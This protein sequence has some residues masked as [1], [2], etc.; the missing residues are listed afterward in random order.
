MKNGRIPGMLRWLMLLPLAAVL[1]S[2]SRVEAPIPEE[3]EQAEEK[4]EVQP[5]EEESEPTETEDATVKTIIS[6][7]CDLAGKLGGSEH[8]AARLM[9]CLQGV[10]NSRFE[11]TGLLV[12]QIYDSTDTFWM[13]YMRENAFSD[14][15]ETTLRSAEEY[16]DFFLPYMRECGLVVWDPSVPATANVASTVCGVEHCLPICL[17]GEPDSLYVILT[18]KGVPVRLSLAD[19]F[20]GSGTIPDTE[21]QSSGSAKCDAYLWA[22]EQYGDR[23]S[24][25]LLAYTLDGAGC[26][27]GNPIYD[28]TNE[29]DPFSNQIY[30][31]DYFVMNRA[32]CFDLT[33]NDE[34]PCDD[35]DQPKG[36]DRATLCQ[37][38]QFAY[39][40]NEG[41]ITQIVG[42]PPWWMKYT[43]FHHN[44]HIGEVALEWQ[45]AQLASTYNCAMEADC[46]H[47]CCM[48]NASLYMWYPLE[49]SYEN[50]EPTELPTF[51]GNTRYFT[52]YI[53]DYDSSAWLKSVI[54]GFWKDRTRGTL[55]LG[56]G[57]NPNLSRRIPMV[58]DYLYK[59]KSD[60]DYFLTGDSGAGY[61]NPSALWQTPNVRELPDGAEAWKRWNQPFLD[62]FDMDVCG[63]ILNGALRWTDEVYRMYH[64]L[65]P[66]G[67][68]S[69]SPEQLVVA[70]GTPILSEV[71]YTTPENAYAA[72]RKRISFSVFRTIRQ[73][74]TQIAEEIE[75]IE[76]Y[77]NGQNDGYT[78]RYVGPYELFELIKQSGEGR[79]LE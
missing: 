60:L 67:G 5:H 58:F 22:L 8:D 39:D 13:K 75:A 73:S 53:G 29:H 77:A 6:Y 25:E 14:F 57:L 64:E 59:N 7:S 17:S 28:G 44:S 50:S 11:E 51:D 15:T 10:L 33:S 56:W 63:F 2:C 24:T 32:F 61:V 49:E 74:P 3:E 69:N 78:Y 72:M 23:C 45:F 70:S 55:P 41:Q 37:I 76:Q 27:P 65:T 30:N 26:L 79:I 71:D 18:E 52:V 46:A 42:F 16:W 9:T 48:T 40:R 47:P 38:L 20:T 68:F 1:C 4:A 35:P 43:V 54:P 62:R 34:R 21:R 31:H 36:T 66:A 12:H 19:K